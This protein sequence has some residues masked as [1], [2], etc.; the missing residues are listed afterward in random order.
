MRASSFSR[1]GQKESK[2]PCPAYD[3]SHTAFS[4]SLQQREFARLCSQWEESVST[5]TAIALSI[6]NNSLF[7]SSQ[8]LTSKCNSSSKEAVKNE[9]HTRVTLGRKDLKISFGLQSAEFHVY[10]QN[11]VR[12]LCSCP[13]LSSPVVEIALLRSFLLNLCQ[14]SVIALRHCKLNHLSILGKGHVC[15]GM[16][17]QR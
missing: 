13:E 16:S 9:C 12:A 5:P 8:V 7:C 11:L 3:G 10:V 15:F 17:W 2:G 14:S 6:G 1:R 4:R